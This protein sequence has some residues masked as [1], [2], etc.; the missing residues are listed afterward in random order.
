MG[1]GQKDFGIYA[2]TT[3]IAGLSDVG[4]L[5]ARLGSPN[6]FDR[7]GN[8]V[9]I[10]SF[11]NDLIPYERAEV[12]AGAEVKVVTDYA[13]T[14]SF[15]CKMTGGSDSSQLARL[16]KSLP[17]PALTKWGFEIGFTYNEDIA[18]IAF[19]IYL[20]DGTTWYQGTVYIIPADDELTYLDE[21]NVRQS[22]ATN[23]GLLSAHTLFNLI[24]LVVDFDSKE[25]V[26][27]ILNETEYSLADIPLYSYASTEGHYMMARIDLVSPFGENQLAYIDEF[28]ITQ[29]EP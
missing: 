5:A 11:D 19:A 2:L 1:R 13:R 18:N 21:N 26:R 28:I 24:K 22:I 8:V 14:S 3:T 16:Q 27:V 6:V 4:E 17:Y 25:Y 12:G 29:N 20:V 9:F 10:D 7:R 23:L 15:S